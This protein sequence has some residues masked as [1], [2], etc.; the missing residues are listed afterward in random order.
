MPRAHRHF[1]P[2]YIWHRTRRCH[3]RAFLLKF[4]RDRQR[5]AP[6]V[7][8]KSEA[9]TLDNTLLWEKTPESAET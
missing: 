2:H 9:L 7:D 4:A 1:L 8:G 6:I 3:E 5:Y